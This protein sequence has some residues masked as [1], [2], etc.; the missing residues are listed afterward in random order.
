MVQTILFPSSYQGLN[1]VDEDLQKE[2]DAVRNTGLYLVVLFGYEKWFCEERL[3]LNNAPDEMTTA[4]YRG[5]MMQPERYEAFYQALLEKNIRLITS[6]EEYRQF[7]VF[8]NVY[9]LIEADTARTMIFP[10]GTPVDLEAVKA[11][12]NRFMVKD[13]VKSVKGTDFP[14]YFENTVTQDEF[15]QWMNVFYKNRGELFTGG[16]CVKEFLELKKYNSRT[17]EYRVFYINHEPATISRNS[18]QTPLAAA[19]PQ[20]LIETYSHLPGKFYTVDYAE[21]KDGSWK[22]VEAG[23]GSVSG[24]SEQQDYEAF[25]RALYQCFK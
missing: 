21:L 23:D 11:R 15:D 12:F 6:P 4:V 3:V 8:P 10:E 14:V 22:I 7:H 18:G 2:Y 20:E 19:P 17:N 24:L 5:W 9:P 16:I 13:Y 25:F 1:K